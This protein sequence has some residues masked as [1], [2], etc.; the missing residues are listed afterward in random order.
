MAGS[1]KSKKPDMDAVKDELERQRKFVTCGADQNKHTNE[2]AF[3]GAYT[4]VGIDNTFSMESSA[5]SSTWRSPR[6]TR[7]R[8][9]SRCAASPRHRECIPPHPHLEVPTMAIEKVFV[10]NNTSIIQDEVFAHRLGLVP[11]RADPRLFEYRSDSEAPSERNT[12]VFKM[13]VKCYREQNADGTK[14]ASSTRW[15]Y[16]T[17]SSGFRTARSSPEEEVKFTSFTQ[18]QGDHLEQASKEAATSRPDGGPGTGDP[19][20]IS[21]V[22]DDILLAKMVAGQ[23]IELEAHCVKGQGKEHAKWSPVGTAWYRMV[24]KVEFL[25]PIVGADADEFMERCGNFSNDH[26]CYECV[27]SGAKKTVKIK[28]ERGCELCLERFRTL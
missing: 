11:I 13:N 10:V 22:H 28:R 26:D 3:S 23:E 8:W 6:S 27:G 1:K 2:H 15:Q 20:T 7:R 14:G 21:T 19:L 12:I 5:S 25:K 17:H 4:S 24:P 9:S 16:S 18:S